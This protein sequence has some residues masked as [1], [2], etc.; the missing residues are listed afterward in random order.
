MPALERMIEIEN[1]RMAF[2]SMADHF[3]ACLCGEGKYKRIYSWSKLFMFL[4]IIAQQRAQ[5]PTLARCLAEN[6]MA[7]K[8]LGM[9]RSLSIKPPNRRWMK[10]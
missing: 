7:T 2:A 5:A 9:S 10:C 6:L 3:D 1:I 4:G 8:R